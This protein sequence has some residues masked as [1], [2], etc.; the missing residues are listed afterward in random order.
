MSDWEIK[1]CEFCHSVLIP[2]DGYEYSEVLMV[3][4]APSL[5][6]ISDF[7]VVENRYARVLSLELSRAGLQYTNMR[8]ISLWR[9]SA[10]QKK[11]PNYASC[12][13]AGIEA[14]V[15]EAQ[16]RKIV[17]LLD[18]EA[19]NTF[20]GK[21]IVETCGLFFESNYFSCPVLVGLSPQAI[22]AGQ[23]GELRI[24]LKRLNEFLYGEDNV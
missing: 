13:Q 11:D 10:L 18:K 23:L 6:A 19:V 24:A 14:V 8:R 12:L 3:F 5:D 7:K 20:L 4:G 22:W 9:H 17:V 15:R 2:P 16:N 21:S 1:Q